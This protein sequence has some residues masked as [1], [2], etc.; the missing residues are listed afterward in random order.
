MTDRLRQFFILSLVI[1]IGQFSF[2]Q[3]YEVSSFVK[4][5]ES[6][7][8]F[9]EALNAEDWFGNSVTGIGDLDGDGVLDV[10]VGAMQDDENGFNKGAIYILFLNPDGSVKRSQKIAQGIGGF[11]EILEDSDIFGVSVSLLGDMNGDGKIE[12][13]VGAEY[14]GD[15]GFHHGAVYILSLNTDGTVFSHQKISSLH[16]GFNGV[17]G[18]WDVFG[19]AVES[20]GD[21]DGDGIQDIAVGARRDDDGGTERG[22]IWILFLNHDFTVKSYQKI[23]STSGNFFGSL[24]NGD[25]FGS[26]IANLGDLNGDGIIDIAVG[27]YRDNDGGSNRG[28]IYILFLNADGTVKS[29][30]KISQTEGGFNDSLYDNAHFGKSIDLIFDI[31]QDGK[32]EILVGNSGYGDYS[33]SNDG[34]FY[35]LNLNSDGTVDSYEKYGANL[36]G[37]EGNLNNNDFFGWSVAYIGANDCGFSVISGAYG[38]SENG[39]QKGAVWVLNIGEPSFNLESFD[40]PTS[41]GSQDGTMT[42]SG[43]T[44][45]LAYTITYNDG[46][47]NSIVQISDA[48]GELVLTGFSSGIYSDITVTENSTGC[49]D[50]LGQIDFIDPDLMMNMISINPSGCVVQDGSITFTGLIANR[51]YR[52]TYFEDVQQAVTQT[53][54]SIGEITLDGLGAGLYK[55]IVVEDILN[56]CLDSVAKVTLETTD[57]DPSMTSES[58]STCSSTDGSLI[59]TGLS[60]GFSYDIAYTL[61]SSTTTKSFIADAN[62]QVIVSGLVHGYYTDLVVEESLTECSKLFGSVD[63]LSPLFTAT[64]ELWDEGVCGTNTGM[65][66]ISDLAPG[67]S[68]NLT[69]N[70]ESVDYSYHYI[71]DSDGTIKVSGL[72]AGIYSNITIGAESSTCQI[73][74]LLSSELACVEDERNCFKTKSFF[75]PNNDGYND[76]WFLETGLNKCD[77]KVFIYDRFGKLLKTLTPEDNKWDG[78][79]KGNNMPSTDYWY[80]INYLNEDQSFQYK[81]NFSLKR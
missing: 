10:A 33:N 73:T 3:V 71:A 2:S 78:T 18:V 74:S 4:I 41:C 80:T 11:N 13:A 35:I 61:E 17:L 56:G 46:A 58:P 28:A 40:N 32:K 57:F 75:T 60:A 49:S 63:L 44:N 5:N 29:R 47:P 43:L 62:G 50:N 36:N 25:Y 68:Y 67:S 59:I 12:I 26:A 23:S 55:N 69:Y 14:D 72:S 8:D 77:Y 53:S 64:I 9:N 37:F 52:I 31:N 51:Q 21:L 6:N 42:I 76:Y 34:S 70:F 1:F 65:M 48:S 54:N 30:Q 7:G 38:D 15:G 79:Y 24:S 20:L 22:A 39:H 19:S 16:G 66:I 27:A 45:N 81:S